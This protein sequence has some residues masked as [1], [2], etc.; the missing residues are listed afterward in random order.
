MTNNSSYLNN[1]KI[2]TMKK[3]IYSLILILSATTIALGQD[4]IYSNQNK[5]PGTMNPSFYGFEEST[6]IG[7]IYGTQRIL[8]NGSDLRNSF[9]FG[10]TY[11]EDYSFSIAV[12]VNLLEVQP[13]GYTSTQANAHYIYRLNLTYDWV[14]NTALSIGYGNNRLDN[15]LIFEDQ[16]NVLT[17]NIAG[18][19]IDPVNAN[20]TVGYFDMGIGAHAHNSRNM[21]FGLNFKHINQP[22]TSF[23]VG[24]SQKRE[25]LISAQAGYEIDLNPYRRGA[26]STNSYLFLYS[27]VAQQGK[28]LRADF[29]Q[30]V[31]L[32]NI[33]FGINQNINS[34]NGAS[35]TTMGASASILLEQ[36]EV[37]ANYS[38]ELASKQLTG[39]GYNYYEIFILFDLFKAPRYKGGNNSRFSNFY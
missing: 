23:N 34:F 39:I 32:D 6:Q 26:F 1:P 22:E 21:F 20:N 14:L 3:Y 2:I 15:S 16:I 27:S 31:I 8:G 38:F 37:G 30:E 13:L 12:D 35:I 9:A 4:F 25:L 29:Y 17:G 19:S 11:F 5:I 7:V 24:N 18:V 28:K 10:T 36:V 33:T